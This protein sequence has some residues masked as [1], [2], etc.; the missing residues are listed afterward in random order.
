M[1]RR[2]LA[3]DVN[4]GRRGWMFST[5][6]ATPAGQSGTSAPVGIWGFSVVFPPTDNSYAIGSTPVRIIRNGVQ[7][8]P[9]SYTDE[10]DATIPQG[11]TSPIR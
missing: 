2:M 9:S 10:G 8:T 5:G 3:W 11:A 1:T 7:W 4:T 6:N